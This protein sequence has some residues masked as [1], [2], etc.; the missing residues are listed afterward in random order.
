VIAVF[1]A[2]DDALQ[3]GV[4]RFGSD[5]FLIR[6]ADRN[7]EEISIPALALDV[8][9]ADSTFSLRCRVRVRTVE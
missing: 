1:E 2:F 9:H 3:E 5:A 4:K 6:R 8:L 7:A